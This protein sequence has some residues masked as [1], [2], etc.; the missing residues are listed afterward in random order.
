MEQPLYYWNPSIAPAGMMFYS[1]SRFPGWKNNLFV[2]G[3]SGMQIARLILDGEKVVGEEKLL[4]DRCQR[5]RGIEQG[6][7]GNIYL[8]TDQMPP[9]QNEILRLVPAPVAPP[10]RQPAGAATSNVSAPA[11]AAKPPEVSL[12]ATAY[13][14]VCAAC[15]GPTGGG[16]SG[17]AIA[18]RTDAAVI[19]DVIRNGQGQMPALGSLL[20]A[21]EIDAITAHIA[22]LGH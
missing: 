15:H 13:M 19:A 2:G 3:L 11:A 12:G 22:Q 7:D 5:F 18:A 16:V 9:A 1:G 8:L 14:R 4:M 20:T 21:P 10:P 6:P 17:P